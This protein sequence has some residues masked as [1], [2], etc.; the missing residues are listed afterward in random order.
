MKIT[1]FAHCSLLVDTGSTR[2]L[3][4]PGIYSGEL[5]GATELDAIIITHQHSDHL[6]INKLK[7]VMAQNEQLKIITHDGPSE[8]LRD[9]SIDHELLQPDQ[10]TVVGDSQIQA[11]EA[12]HQSIYQDQGLVENLGFIIDDF[13]FAGDS[14]HLP[15]PG[16][17]VKVLALPVVAPWL[18][19]SEAIDFAIKVKPKFCIPVH[20]GFLNTGGPFYDWPKKVLPTENIEFISL[21]DGA[22]IEL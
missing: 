11:F 13:C 7:L 6:D 22:T 2:I 17:S 16:K 20:D 3:F 12:P 18:K 4:D 19:I 1:K 15:P 9:A 10:E 8:I 5:D 14:L 21:D